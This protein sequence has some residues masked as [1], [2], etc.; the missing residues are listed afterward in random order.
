MIPGAV[1]SH[2]KSEA[3]SVDQIQVDKAHEALGISWDILGYLGISWDP[4][5][6]TVPCPSTS[7]VCKS[8]FLSN[9]RC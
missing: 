5:R 9:V 6:D 3:D 1:E 4:V 8:I 2:G 7:P